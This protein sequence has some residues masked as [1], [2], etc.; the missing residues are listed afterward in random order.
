MAS[1]GMSLWFPHVC[2]LSI[3]T[4]KL[5]LW[6]NSLQKFRSQGPLCSFVTMSG[7]VWQQLASCLQ[8]MQ[9]ASALLQSTVHQ[10]Q[11]IETCQCTKQGS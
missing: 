10:K 8:S 5:H 7:S 2:H 3:P 1:R 11:G 9:F 6:M 4:W